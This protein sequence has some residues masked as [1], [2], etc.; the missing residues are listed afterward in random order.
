LGK[1]QVIVGAKR[2]RTIF[3][4]IVGSI[5]EFTYLNTRLI[6]SSHLS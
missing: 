5:H 6:Y 4:E 3:E 2:V 1:F